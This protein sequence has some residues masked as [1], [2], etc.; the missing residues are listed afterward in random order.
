MPFRMGIG[1]IALI[2]GIILIVLGAGKLPEAFVSIGKAMR[3][4]KRAVSGKNDEG[5]EEESPD[6]E[7]GIKK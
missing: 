3:D 7:Q 6:T 4:F 2:L 1:E 5:K